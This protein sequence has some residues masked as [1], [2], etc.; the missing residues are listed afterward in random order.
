MSPY[1]L[2]D[3]EGPRQTG[4]FDGLSAL[5]AYFNRTSKRPYEAPSLESYYTSRATSPAS[6]GTDPSAAS[7]EYKPPGPPVRFQ[8]DTLGDWT[9]KALDS[10]IGV[11]AGLGAPEQRGGSVD[12]MGARIA[13]APIN[14]QNFATWAREAPLSVVT[15]ILGHKYQQPEGMYVEPAGPLNRENLLEN[16]RQA[17]FPG[18]VDNLIDGLTTVGDAINAPF[19]AFANW[20]RTEAAWTRAEGVAQLFATGRG[21][22]SFVQ[23]ITH[24]FDEDGLQTWD[25]IARNAAAQGVTM[26]DMIASAWDLSP[27]VVGEIERGVRTGKYKITSSDLFGINTTDA[28][29][30]RGLVKDEPFSYDPFSSLIAELGITLAPM[31][32]GAG[33]LRGLGLAL[34]GLKAGTVASGVR[35]TGLA[36]SAV[37]EL[38][39]PRAAAA[40]AER[41]G[42]WSLPKAWRYVRAPVKAAGAVTGFSPTGIK[43]GAAIRFGE[44]SFKQAATWTG[45]QGAIDMA[46]RWLNETPLSQNPGLMMLDAFAVHP[47]AGAKNLYVNV[48]G[49]GKVIVSRS[50]AK[51]SESFAKM[52]LPELQTRLFDRLGWEPG[53]VAGFI[54]DEG[55]TVG[56]DDLKNGI[57]H[58]ALEVVRERHPEA[59]YLAAATDIPTREA[60]FIRQYG[61]EAVKV[62]RDNLSGADDSI[63]KAITEEFW[64]RERIIAGSELGLA[65]NAGPYHPDTALTHLVSWLRGSKALQAAYGPDTGLVLGLRT[66]VNREFVRAFRESLRADYPRPGDTIRQADLL[67]LTTFVPAAKKAAG[68]ILGGSKRVPKMTRHAVEVMLD[69]LEKMQE[70]TDLAAARP[71]RAAA[72]IAPGDVGDPIAVGAAMKLRKDTIEALERASTEGVEGM[73]A[74]PGDLANLLIELYGTSKDELLRYPAR[75]WEKAI[76]WYRIAYDSAVVRGQ[77][78]ATLGRFERAVTGLPLE[79]K[80]LFTVALERLNAAIENPPTGLAPGQKVPS[81]L[82]SAALSARDQ[83]VAELVDRIA[84]WVDDPRREMLTEDIGDGPV[85]RTD[86]YTAMMARNIRALAGRVLEADARTPLDGLTAEGRAILGSPTAHPLDV[87]RVI[88]ESGAPLKP[89]DTFVNG[90]TDLEGAYGDLLD[91]VRAPGD[92]PEPVT[93]AA[94]AK[95]TDEVASLRAE[96]QALV[97]ETKSLSAVVA[98]D[99]RRRV[100]EDVRAITQKGNAIAVT[101]IRRAK[102]ETGTVQPWRDFAVTPENAQVVSNEADLAAGRKLFTDRIAERQRIADTFAADAAL[103]SDRAGDKFTLDDFT[104]EDAPMESFPTAKAARDAMKGY[105]EGGISVTMR[106]VPSPRGGKTPWQG[107]FRGELKE[108]AAAPPEGTAFAP[109]EPG[110]APPAAPLEATPALPEAPRPAPVIVE[111]MS[112]PVRIAQARQDA[113]DAAAAARQEAFAAHAEVFPGK[114]KVPVVQQAGGWGPIDGRVSFKT[115]KE[116]VAGAQRTDEATGHA[117]RVVKVEAGWGVEVENVAAISGNAAESAAM[118]RPAPVEVT[119]L[120]PKDNA[121]PIRAKVVLID[122]ADVL[123]SADE[124][125]PAV[126]QPRDRSGRVESDKQI[127]RIAANVQ[128]DKLLGVTEGAE[129]MPV[130]APDGFVLS[131]NGRTQGLRLASATEFG[132]YKT[133]LVES[134]AAKYGF[135]PAE[136]AAMDRP[137]LFRMLEDVDAPTMRRLAFQLNPKGLADGEVAIAFA[138]EIQAADI[139]ALKIAEKQDLRDALAADKNAALA[140][141]VVERLPLD[142]RSSY[143]APDG[144]L[145][146]RGVKIV[147]GAIF[148]KLLRA[149]VPGPHQAAAR[150]LVVTA[151][152][153]GGEEMRRVFNGVFSGAGAMLRAQAKADAGTIGTEFLGTIDTL[154]DALTEILRRRRNDSSMAQIAIELQTV[155][156]FAEFAAPPQTKHMGAILASSSTPA[157]IGTFLRAIAKAAEGATPDGFFEATAPVETTGLLNSGVR[158]WNAARKAAGKTKLDHFPSAEA[159]YDVPLSAARE[160]ENGATAPSVLASQPFTEAADVSASIEARAPGPKR[161]HAETLR[162]ARRGTETPAGLE[163]RDPAERAFAEA[164]RADPEAVRADVIDAFD[165]AATFTDSQARADYLRGLVQMAN[166]G[167]IGPGDWAVLESFIFPVRRNT[168]GR[169]NTVKGDLVETLVGTWEPHVANGLEERLAQLDWLDRVVDDQTAPRLVMDRPQ[170]ALSEADLHAITGPDVPHSPDTPLAREIAGSSDQIVMH[171]AN[172][173]T[174]AAARRAI[175]APA[176]RPRGQRVLEFNAPTGAAQAERTAALAQQARGAVEAAQAELAAYDANPPLAPQAEQATVLGGADSGRWQGLMAAADDILPPSEPHTVGA[177]LDAIES[178]DRGYVGALT[179]PEAQALRSTLIRLADGALNEATGRATAAQQRTITR[180]IRQPDDWSPEELADAT[181]QLLDDIAPWVVTDPALAPLDGFTGTQYIITPPPTGGA[182]TAI[183]PRITRLD[184]L[185]SDL[186]PGLREELASGRMMEYGE[187]VRRSRLISAIDHV[188]GPRSSRVIREHGIAN[189]TQALEAYLPDGAVAET[190]NLDRAVGK[191]VEAWLDAMSRRKIGSYTI[192]RRIDLIGRDE[193]D[194]IARPIF[195]AEAPGTLANLD[196]NG[197]TLDALWRRADNRVRQFIANSNLPLSSMVERYYGRVADSKLGRGGRWATVAYHATRFTLEVRWLGLEGTEPLLL[198]LASGGPVAYLEGRSPTRAAKARQPLGFG[199]LAQKSY[200][201]DYAHWTQLT[202][203]EQSTPLR[204]RVLIRELARRQERPF[205]DTVL[206]VAAKDPQLRRMMV[207]FGENGVPIRPRQLLDRLDRDFTMLEEGGRTFPT[208]A[209]ASGFFRPW[210]DAGV[211]DEPTFREYV[212]ARKYSAHPAIE[213]EIRASVGNPVATALYGRLAHINHGLMNDLTAMFFGQENRSNLQRVLNHP[214]L[215]WPVSYQI[216]ATKWLLRF[217]GEEALG[218][219][220]GALGAVALKRVYEEHKDRMRDDPIYRKKLLDNQTLYFLASMVLPISP[221]DIGVSLSPWARLVGSVT[222]LGPQYD[223]PFGVAGWGSFTTY[224]FISR[225]IRELTSQQL[226]PPE[227]EDLFP[228]TLSVR[229]KRDAAPTSQMGAELE[230]TAPG[231]YQPPEQYEVPRLP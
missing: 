114:V 86:V 222:G 71:T 212:K 27:A 15:S 202:D 3:E 85:L 146:K 180:R 176:V 104:W 7:L 208:E 19:V 38:V 24:L 166:D 94:V 20:Q 163:L 113:W 170:T 161:V 45:N 153:L 80:G 5:D 90:L 200:M 168:K 59:A 26:N 88:R 10:P 145:N 95:L 70:T 100:A 33:E 221:W 158:A 89:T 53:K 201:K 9:Q 72:A 187:R 79:E 39:G 136:A 188:I 143:I 185:E 16:V 150:D 32:V 23:V 120:D 98:T 160:L 141:R 56:L 189:F 62:I 105:S 35:G 117:T 17:D 118:S 174:E 204:W 154:S 51:M 127:A 126:F 173:T 142:W 69:D 43:I 227:F 216:K 135:D 223:R 207:D 138:D 151:I 211:I 102:R 25:G 162:D 22:P 77:T 129:G 167:T 61:D 99:P 108:R 115:R 30:L 165:A 159:P 215:F 34:K 190:Q 87:A 194:A 147:E 91:R 192:A 218:V 14:A 28:D 12:F 84:A 144:A 76:E 196:A 73:G 52:E 140:R 78:I 54:N 29:E 198:P 81:P 41:I 109:A 171:A 121:T 44:W 210:L 97:D 48:R 156:A 182:E 197:V 148:A 213:A 149:D 101:T 184:Y 37:A 209:A 219:D 107:V 124:A 164:Y 132:K 119:F 206:D 193:L 106:P 74:L 103:A 139:D 217:M 8:F 11:A 31:L 60:A 203:M 2:P 49:Y 83:R 4:A 133:R 122:A 65:G 125:Y 82:I 195:E 130:I 186:L 179:P 112:E 36:G 18:V 63:V 214:F 55:S 67:R 230:R 1:G 226:L 231:P 116:A 42:A 172:P 66:D 40:V 128:P 58:V 6:R 191:V 175:G 131:G 199:G 229:R 92:M 57:I 220:T 181:T 96:R 50:F 13:T 225:A 75:A 123:T 64:T 46:D 183:T 155:D 110:S 169:I 111:R 47:L 21:T 157:E 205:M 93:A 178:I 137:V 152:E 224:T 228:R 177:L 134:E 68:G